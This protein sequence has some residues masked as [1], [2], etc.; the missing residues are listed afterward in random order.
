MREN[1]KSGVTR[2]DFIR[3][4]AGAVLATS[5]IGAEWAKGS[6]NAPSSP[7][8][9]E[10]NQKTT[11]QAISKNVRVIEKSTALRSLTIDEGTTLAAPAGKSLTMTVDGIG[12]A[13]KP[14]TYKGDIF[15]TVADS[16]FMPPSGLGRMMK[17]KEFR[18]AIYMEDGKYV[19]ER[20]VPA[21][22]QGGKVT[23]KAIVGVSI[24]GCDDSFNGI[25]V[26]GKSDYTIDKVKIDFE[27][28]G[29]NDFIGLGAGIICAGN[30]KVTIND[31]TIKLN[32]VTR[33]AVDVCAN[34]VA[35]FN[36]CRISN[37]SPPTARMYPT[38]M[39]GLRGSNR[40]T[41]HC[42][43]ATVYYNNCYVSSNGWG[44]LSVDGGQRVRMFVKNSTIELTGPR[45]RGYGAFSIGDCL[46]SFDGCT[47]NVQ[48]YPILMGNGEGICNAE[49]TGGTVVNSTLY[50]AMIFRD[51]GSELKVN[52]G[53]I[54]NTDSSTFVVKGSNTHINVDNAVLN[55]ANGV[56]LQLM[57]NDGPDMTLPT[58]K[59]PVGEIDATIPGRDLTIADP[60]ED[61]FMTVAN[62]EVSG[63]FYNSTTN[64]KAN[65]REKAAG[66]IAGVP[67]MP[68]MDTSAGTPAGMENMEINWEAHQGVK[69]LDLKFA[70]A[71][72][73]GIISAANAAYKNGVTVIDVGNNKE[74][75]AVTQTAQEPVNNGVIVSFD[76]DCVWIVAGTS[77]LTS[78][79]VARG[80]VIKPPEAKTLTMTVN[81]V[82]KTIAPGT[83]TG[84]IVI[85]IA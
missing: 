60:K 15:I 28:E 47:M 36:N 66:G 49:I 40:A 85:T 20:S 7:A 11:G 9:A 73:K 83:Y 6:E 71:K 13:M 50:G 39:F 77:Y 43:Y 27:G 16:F 59:V 10:G 14:G 54:L 38:W 78:L 42:D 61:V 2:R 1:K 29:A 56:I 25:I 30:S 8:E 17:A 23:D 48:G 75:S 3:G 46:I 68:E 21:I 62:M 34:S 64:L 80:A 24:S 84:K 51:I 5:I 70:K 76:K 45:A 33:C 19:P 44:V 35:T 65:C 18:A 41:M 58:F 72:V 69:N 67:G 37:D 55:P 31:S 52:K 53:A 12:T 74:I 57:D 26:T 82:K 4:S 22:V 79:T 32:G 81:G 63:D